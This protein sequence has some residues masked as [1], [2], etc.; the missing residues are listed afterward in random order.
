MAREC[1]WCEVHIWPLVGLGLV[2]WWMYVWV[3]LRIKTNRAYSMRLW[4][5]Y[6]RC[7]F[8]GIVVLVVRSLGRSPYRTN[9]NPTIY[10][11][12]ECVHAYHVLRFPPT[13]DLCA[14][15]LNPKT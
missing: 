10:A 4:L 5:V 7:Q 13:Y 14:Q 6:G 2:Y 11:D 8:L 12:S 1:H 9:D 3:A 15:I